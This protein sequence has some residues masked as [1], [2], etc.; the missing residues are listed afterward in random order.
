VERN[1]SRL[2]I[3]MT[4]TEHS[5]PTT[6][7][8]VPCY[9]ESGRIG[10]FVSELART[11]AD[12]EGVRVLLVEDGSG[13]EEQ[14]RFM[15][16]VKP[17]IA[18]RTLFEEPLL[19]PENLGKGGAVYEGWTHHKGQ[20]WLAF[21]D[22]DGACSALETR[23]L[24]ALA[25]EAPASDSVWFASRVKMLGKTVKRFLHRHLLG[26]IYATLVSE[27][28]HIPVYDSQCGLKVVPRQ[29]WEI[30]HPWL[31]EKG[32][33]FDVE[34]MT[35]FLDSGLHVTEVPVDWTEIPGGKVRLV[36]DSIRMFEEVLMIRH[37]RRSSEWHT[38]VAELRRAIGKEG[39][40]G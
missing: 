15:A 39:T 24:L 30:L 37:R 23:R 22:A 26:R 34:L 5:L 28:L 21:V 8:V 9:R 1:R 14:A 20:D 16:V 40:S 3:I 19:L 27:L 31:R 32:F 7:L 25:G 12:G 36:R 11:F 35:A 10:D 18:G 33:A 6:F 13:A 38:A 29:A 17:L 4:T 2:A